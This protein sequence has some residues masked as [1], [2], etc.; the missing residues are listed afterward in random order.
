MA[1][2]NGTRLR[3]HAKLYVGFRLWP[4]VTDSLYLAM[5][6]SKPLIIAID[7]GAGTG[8]STAA[9]GIAR[10]LGI[11][12]LN[13]GELY[14][15]I[16]F[17]VI[18]QNL[19]PEDADKVQQLTGSID[20]GLEKGNVTSVNGLD[21]RGKLH[22]EDVNSLVSVVSSHPSVR[23]EIVGFQRDYAKAN[24]VVMEGRDIGTRIFPKAPYKFFFVCDPA[25]RVRRVNAGGRSHETVEALLARDAADAAKSVGRFKQPDDAIVIDTTHLNSEAVIGKVVDHVRR[26]FSSK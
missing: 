22:L 11:P 10:E 25:E 16:T 24:G 15:A 21:V 26:T 14:R 20:F 12:H 1:S 7:G 9:K 8:T 13:T 17:E 3:R 5:M 18:R 2:M 23:D 6:K 4:S 19:D